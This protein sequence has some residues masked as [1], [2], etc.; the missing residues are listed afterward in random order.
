MPRNATFNVVVG[1]VENEV[2]PN[3]LWGVGGNAPYV[4]L[5]EEGGTWN[6]NLGLIDLP[7]GGNIP[8]IQGI[9]VGI[10]L[11]GPLDGDMTGNGVDW[12]FSNESGNQWDFYPRFNIPVAP[13]ENW[14][15]AQIESANRAELPHRPQPGFPNY[16][17]GASIGFLGLL[18]IIEA[19]IPSD[20]AIVIEKATNGEDADTPTGPMVEV[21]DPV[22]WTYVVTNTGNVTLTERDGHR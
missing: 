21:G 14:A 20:P 2:R 3:G 7:G 1:G 6:Q 19:E 9:G 5:T 10:E 17:F 15:C 4:N 18:T 12:P 11:D 16:N 13:G 22:T 8:A